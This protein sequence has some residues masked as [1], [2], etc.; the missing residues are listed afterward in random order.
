[1]QQAILSALA[2]ASVITAQSNAFIVAA[3]SHNRVASTTWHVTQKTDD[4]SVGTL[5]YALSQAQSGDAVVFDITERMDVSVALVVPA[6]VSVGAAR[7]QACVGSYHNAILN[8]YLNAALNPAMSLGA[9]ATLRNVNFLHATP[10]GS[11]TLRVIGDD[12]DVC[13]VGMGIGYGGDGDTLT[14]PPGVAAI[15]VDGANANIHRNDINGAVIVTEN[16][17]G[18]HIGDAVGG[19]GGS[20]QANTGY[21]GNQGKCAVSILKSSTKAARNVT[22]RD[23]LPRTLS[24]I[25]GAGTLGGDDVV[26][27]TNHWAGTPVVVSALSADN[28]A[29][30]IVKGTASPHSLIDIFLDDGVLSLARQ[31]P[32]TADA[33]GA[34]T[35]TGALPGSNIFVIA[36]S[37]LNDPAHIGRVGSTS[38]WSG[39]VKVMAGSGGSTA[40]STPA[41]TATHTSTPTS[42]P[43]STPTSTSTSTATSTAIATATS[44]PTPTQ[45]STPTPTSTPTSTPTHTPTPTLDNCTLTISNGQAYTN[46]PQVELRTNVAGATEILLSNDGGFVNTTWQPYTTHISW[47][48]SDPGQRISTLL[49]YARFRNANGPLCNGSTLIDDIIYDSLVPQVTMSQE[50]RAARAQN[51]PAS[52]GRGVAA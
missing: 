8:I 5:S 39:A 48:L 26:T 16:G 4:G 14:Q 23:A 35:F 30:V 51:R 49:V 24:G 21:C 22:V 10:T 33:T 45:T 46:K 3:S 9:G 20:G 15:I 41:A 44:T 1:M 12:V 19:A 43:T 31:A 18:T 25:V 28:F 29:S 32:V 47:T 13:G 27:H 2:I 7:S 6:G 38:Q 17:S 40:T 11:V 37:T 42:I 36:I 50:A 52:L 34:F